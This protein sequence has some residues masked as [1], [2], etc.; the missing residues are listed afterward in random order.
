M[1]Y[2]CYAVDMASTL[3]IRNVPADLHAVIAEHARAQGLTI[4]QYLL[5]RLAQIE[6]KPEVGHTLDAHWERSTHRKR[7]SP[8][9]AAAV[10]AEDRER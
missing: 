6:G 10:V 8:G 7:A 1:R 5:R 4:S 9:A 2:A 3:Q